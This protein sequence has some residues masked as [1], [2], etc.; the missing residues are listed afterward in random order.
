MQ[1]ERKKVHSVSRENTRKRTEKVSNRW[2]I[3]TVTAV[4]ICMAFVVNL[5]V[6]AL[7]E[8]DRQYTERLANITQEIQYEQDRH[9]ELLEHKIFVQ[10]KEYVAEVAKEKLG[11]VF[12]GEILLKPK[13][14][15]EK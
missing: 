14:G 8:K 12:P 1:Q 4:V 5:K 11:L 2:A 3:I 13:K 6:T 9:E 15:R 10:T 7:K